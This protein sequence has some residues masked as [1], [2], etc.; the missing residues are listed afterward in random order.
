MRTIPLVAVLFV[1]CAISLYAGALSKKVVERATVYFEARSKSLAPGNAQA[2][3]QL[4]KQAVSQCAE[5]P[6]LVVVVEAVVLQASLEE[7]RLATARIAAVK[8]VLLQAGTTERSIYE[9]VVSSS[10]LSE[11][12]NLAGESRQ[13]QPG[14]VELE[15]VCNAK[16]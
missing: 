10:K 14:T 7:S 9:D 6:A 16:T 4:L 11:R 15:I 13:P 1:G 8:A 3:E 2:V 5:V 12:R